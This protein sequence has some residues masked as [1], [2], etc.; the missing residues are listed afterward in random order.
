[1]T[2]RTTIAAL[3]PLAVLLSA[4]GKSGSESESQKTPSSVVAATTPPAPV[5]SSPGE[6]MQTLPQDMLVKGSGYRAEE[7]PCRVLAPNAF[8]EKY[9]EEQRTLVACPDREQAAVKELLGYAGAKRL[10]LLDDHVLLSL[11][12]SH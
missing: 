9:Q 8:V 6:G 12:K 3:L 11:P 1:M 2:S 4:C 10:A 7:D 5:P